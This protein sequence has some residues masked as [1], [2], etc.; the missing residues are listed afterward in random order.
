MEAQAERYEQVLLV[1]IWRAVWRR[2]WLFLGTVLVCLLLSLALAFMMEPYYQAEVVVSPVTDTGS[3]S[4]LTTMVGKLGG[5]GS[6]E[7]IGHG[8]VIPGHKFLV[9]AGNL[10]WPV[11]CENPAHLIERDR[12]SLHDHRSSGGFRLQ[13]TAKPPDPATRQWPL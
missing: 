11:A 12:H 4:A 9:L 13:I 3:G 7:D 5:I 6:P 1:D 10:T 2:K 8:V